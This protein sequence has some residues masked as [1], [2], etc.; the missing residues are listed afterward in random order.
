M[1]NT[2]CTRYS[3]H[4]T[5]L[6][7]KGMILTHRR[8]AFFTPVANSESCTFQQAMVQ[9]TPTVCL[10]VPFML[11]KREGKKT[12]TLKKMDISKNQS[13]PLL[14]MSFF[15]PDFKGSEWHPFFS[16]LVLFPVKRPN[17][18]ILKPWV[19]ESHTWRK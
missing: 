15:G 1:E 16:I 9:P 19:M 6:T 8:K 11:K 10:L 7:L 4:L 12:K 14:S 18:E 3:I 2:Y 17:S 5:V 13:N